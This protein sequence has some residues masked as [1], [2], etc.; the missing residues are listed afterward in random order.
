[1]LNL[2]GRVAE[3]TADNIFILKN[4]KLKTPRLTEGALPGVTRAAVLQLAEEAGIKT[5]Q[6]VLG[7]HDLYN[8]EECFLTGTG[9]EIVPVITID[10]RQIGSG[11]PGKTTLDLLDRFRAMRVQ[12]GFKV[13]FES[14]T[15]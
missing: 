9:A 4:G 3:C 7:L 13:A 15:A 14:A 11:R 8:A 6:T 2:S 10:G 5:K 12:D 1:M